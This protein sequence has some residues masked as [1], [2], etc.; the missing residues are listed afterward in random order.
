MN[1]LDF[2][3]GMGAGFLTY[4]G[5]C[6]AGSVIRRRLAPDVSA[7]P[8]KPG[9]ILDPPANPAPPPRN[10]SARWKWHP[11]PGGRL[12]LGAT[13]YYVVLN[14]PPAEDGKQVQYAGFTPEHLRIVW[15]NDLA[16]MKR[17]LETEAAERAEFD[18]PGA[19]S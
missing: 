10:P 19:A 14:P 11:M 17:T 7:E 1:W 4:E 9:E 12:E 13:G 8:I 2:F 18:L 3:A 6:W 15:G 5:A 16:G